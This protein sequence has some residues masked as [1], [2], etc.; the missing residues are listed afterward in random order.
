MR[1]SEFNHLVSDAYGKRL[2]VAGDDFHLYGFGEP[3]LHPKLTDMITVST[4]FGITSKINTNGLD[5]TPGIWGK[6]REAGL[7]KALFSLDGVTERDYKKYRIGGDFVRVRDNIAYAC[8]NKGRTAIEV[9]MIMFNYNLDAERIFLDY[10]RS[11][12][13]DV[14]VLKKP[15]TWKGAGIKYKGMEN[16][17][18]K[19]KRQSKAKSLKTFE[20]RG[21]VLFNGDLTVNN[22]DPQGKFKVGNIFA[23]GPELWFSKRFDEM[24]QRSVK[25]EST[26]QNNDIYSKKIVIQ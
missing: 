26:D 5:C 14:A 3:T 16:L 24:V 7:T 18:E 13:A 2:V 15:R 17:P 12:G 1:F 10:V 4:S 25:E 19:V 21:A 9:Q 11:V 22:S 6:L 23:E 8:A 20:E